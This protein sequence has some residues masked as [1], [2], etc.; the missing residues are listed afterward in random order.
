LDVHFR[1][2]KEAGYDLRHNTVVKLFLGTSETA[3]RVR[4]LGVEVLHPGE[5]GWLQLEL[6]APVA[7]E[8]GD[9]YLLWRPSPGE[10]LGGGEVV[11]PDPTERHK[12]F[13]PAVIQRLESYLSGTPDEML[14]QAA[15]TAGA[16]K[17]AALAS[18]A[19][20]ELTVA[21]QAAVLLIT[22]GRLIAL[23]GEGQE[24]DK[25][26][27]LPEQ[28]W[29]QM[30]KAVEEIV[31]QFHREHPLR[32][33]ML[34]EDLRRQLKASPPIFQAYLQQ[35]KLEQIVKITDTMAALPGFEVHFSPQQQRAIDVL[36][37]CFAQTPYAP[38]SVKECQTA[39]GADTYATLLESGILKQLSADVVISNAVYQEWLAFVRLHFTQHPT[40][41]V[42]EFRDA[43]AT[44]RKYALAF[45]EYL[46]AQ[47]L[48]LREDNFRRLKVNNR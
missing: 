37:A 36:M 29:K 14:L 40:L 32:A 20:M 3:A 8:R 15:L 33:G 22:D 21:R 10:L 28:S 12:R 26:L 31:G 11:I 24:L 47:G 4:L 46:D 5:T 6:A 38:P 18:A 42:I 44:S 48:T 7:A 34:K 27:F 9:R 17:L 1:L 25:A 19:K 43:F 16:A 23:G 39:V 41:T 35:L 2:V 30:V 13:D 45:L